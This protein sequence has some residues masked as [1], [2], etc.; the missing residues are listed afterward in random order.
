MDV[1]DEASELRNGL[2][3]VFAITTALPQGQYEKTRLADCC[4]P[5]AS[6]GEREQLAEIVTS[7]AVLAGGRG[8]VSALHVFVCAARNLGAA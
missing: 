8:P 3:L 4:L 1:G 5:R 6:F 7:D 2:R